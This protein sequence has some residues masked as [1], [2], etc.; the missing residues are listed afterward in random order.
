MKWLTK[1]RWPSEASHKPASG[2]SILL[3]QLLFIVVI[4]IQIMA[5]GV[6]PS[7]QMLFVLI[8]VF[9]IW[10]GESRSLLRA[11]LPF[12]LLLFSYET[13]RG[14]ADNLNV[15]SVHVQELIDAELTL[16]GGTLP[17]VFLQNQL[18]HR[19]YTGWINGVANFFY[20]THFVV[21]VIA[22]ITLWHREH[23]QYWR[24]ITGLVILSYVG[25][26]TYILYPAAPPW[27]ATYHGYLTDDLAVEYVISPEFL[28]ETPNPVA[29]M[30]SL[31][32]AY[33]TYIALVCVWIWGKKALPMFLLPLG[34]GVSAVYLAHHY[35][36]DLLVGAIYS[37]VIFATVYAL[38]RQIALRKQPVATPATAILP[39][40]SEPTAPPANPEGKHSPR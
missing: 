4:S 5:Y 28:L 12:F 13:L 14:Y 6:F 37:L 35:V 34:V 23:S 24:F 29:A 40:V 10:H 19:S 1:H 20:M 17:T 3:L 38:P 39:F 15:A 30:P 8:T 27:W 9:L 22:A 31:H 32:A 7:L 21:P 2:Q 33:P 11:F 16:F 26:L 25:F 36:I 18:M